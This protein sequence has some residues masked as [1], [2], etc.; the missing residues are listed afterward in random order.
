MSSL[1]GNKIIGAILFT[2]LAAMA[3]S[4]IGNALI[5]QYHVKHEKA[6]EAKDAGDQQPQT[7]EPEKPL[8][9]LLAAATPEAGQKV[10][11][12]CVSCHSF[13]KGGPNKVGPNLYDV[14]GRKPGTHAG[15]QYSDAIKGLK[16]DW[17]YEHLYKYLS[18]PATYAKGTKMAFRLAK[19]DER[20]NVIVY[21]RTLSE[22]P[23]PL[24]AKP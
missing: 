9:E 12:K 4:T 22:S 5:P 3:I 10:A 23:K 18:N 13:D 2:A 17:D 7:Q 1:E 14:V 19:S 11:Q 6:T 15:Y 20:A 24:P 8:A 21:L 16:D